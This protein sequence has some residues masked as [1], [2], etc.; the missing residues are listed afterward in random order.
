MERGQNMS[1]TV[2]RNP[3]NSVGLISVLY[4]GTEQGDV[5]EALSAEVYTARQH[6]LLQL[7]IMGIR[8]VLENPIVYLIEDQSNFHQNLE[9]FKESGYISRPQVDNLGSEFWKRRDT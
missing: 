3:S 1:K 9:V 6:G 5:L 2:S 7:T 4:I 8:E